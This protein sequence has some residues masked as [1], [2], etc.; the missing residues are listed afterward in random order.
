MSNQRRP[1]ANRRLPARRTRSRANRWWVV[2]A[3]GALAAGALALAIPIGNGADAPGS[4]AASNGA[5]PATGP[6][7][8]EVLETPGAAT[9]DASAGGVEVTGAEWEM[10][11]VP[12]NVTVTPEWRLRNTS[13]RP[14]SLG[15][16]LAEVVEGCCPGSLNLS[17]TTLAPGEVARLDFPLQMHPGMDGWHDFRVHVPVVP[18]GGAE[19][20]L[21]LGVTGDFKD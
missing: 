20:H 5:T 14:V 2:V 13:D 4:R 19:E 9:G 21:T 3:G 8:G 17:A 16:P 18:E 11:R 15:T 1:A 7:G 12:L 10:G 6:M